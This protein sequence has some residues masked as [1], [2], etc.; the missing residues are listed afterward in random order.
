MP[1]PTFNPLTGKFD[2]VT[3]SQAEI[4]DIASTYCPYTGATT[5]VNLG[6]NDLTANDVVIPS[7]AL[8]TPTYSTLNDFFKLFTSAGRLTGGAITD[9]GSST[10]S[11]AAGTGVIRIADDDTSQVKFFDW[12]ATTGLS[13]PLNTVR[14]IGVDYNTGTAAITVEARTTQNWDLDTEFP[15]GSVINQSGTLY[16]INDPWWVGD[17]LTN[18]IERFQSEGTVRDEHVGGLIIGTSGANTT[19]KPTLTA[20]T[21]WSRLSEFSISAKDCSA[22]STFYGFYRDGSGGWTRTAAK[23]DIDDYYDNNSGTLQALGANKYVN[24]WMFAE[25][26]APNSGQLMVIYPQNQYNTAAS[27][28]A[29]DVPV[30]PSIWYKHGILLGRIQIKQGVTAPIEVQSAFNIQFGYALAADHGNLSG[31]SDNDHPQYLLLD[32]S[33]DPL[34]GDLTI[35]GDIDI[36]LTSLGDIQVIDSSSYTTDVFSIHNSATDEQITTTADRDFSSD[37]GHWTLGTGWSITGGKLVKAAGTDSYADL[38]KIYF[39][40]EPTIFRYYDITYTVSDRTAGTVRP[41]FGS[42]GSNNNTNGTFTARLRTGSAATNYLRFYASSTFDGKIDNVSIKRVK[43]DFRMVAD[44]KI[45]QGMT[46]DFP[47]YWMNVDLG[48]CSG[49]PMAVRSHNPSFKMTCYRGDSGQSGA[50]FNIFELYAQNDTTSANLVN[51]GALGS[52]VQG[53]TPTFTYF[54]IGLAYNNTWLTVNTTT[55]TIGYGQAGVDW[56]LKFDGETNDGIITWME[57]EDY[58]KFSDDIML[59]GGENIILD[60]TTGTKIGT[61]TSQLLGF[62]NATPVNQ[63]DTVSDAA[64]QDLTGTDTV[65]KTKLEADLTSCKNTIN[66]VID[67]LQELGLIA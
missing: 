52:M 60:T 50:A 3:A 35:N 27:A 51:L 30:L 49:Y 8:G 28:E 26:D 24:F 9:G 53:G 33:N 31:L 67:R 44:G 19:R 22:T 55:V 18:I 23:T 25:V 66:T 40:E 29:E 58:F 6:S 45:N 21:V 61:A 13:V 64:T 65:D 10:V 56:I 47:Q 16:I 15:L 11:V 38:P 36:N 59:T 34:T 62:Y 17:G 20:G 42:N 39:E 4:P 5:D 57:D 46:T 41:T 32:C 54:Y 1:K 63:P 37:T 14:Y 43:S 2:M 12:I 7:M 48:N